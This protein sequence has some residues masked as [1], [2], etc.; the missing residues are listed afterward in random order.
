MRILAKNG[1]AGKIVKVGKIYRCEAFIPTSDFGRKRLRHQDT[2]LERV[3][4]HLRTL[5]LRVERAR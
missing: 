3:E 5:G 4:K 1:E 2:S